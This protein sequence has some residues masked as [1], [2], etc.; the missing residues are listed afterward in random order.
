MNTKTILG[1]IFLSLAMT[2][3]GCYV[4]PETKSK[5][6]TINQVINN[7][8]KATPQALPSGFERREVA[9]ADGR[10]VSWILVTLKTD[11]WSWSLANDPSKPKTVSSWRE[12]L[13]ANLVINGSYFNQD[14]H[15]SGYYQEPNSSSS[16]PW[17]DL[18]AQKKPDSYSGLLKIRDG[19]LE[20]SHLTDKPQTKPAKNE[21]ALLTYP[22]LLANGQPLVKEDSKKY[23]RRTIL[24]QDAEGTTYL[25]I[26]ETGAL[27]LYEASRWLASQPEKFQIAINL[28]GGP[29][30]GLS[31]QTSGSSFEIPSAPIPNVITGI[32]TGQ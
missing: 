8:P 20:I 9:Y 16:K 25:V 1:I 3:S 7:Q 19:K 18:A 22:T 27:S 6:L 5:P 11:A 2:G 30:T 24:A 32:L 14:Y 28:D 31:Y 10:Q 17:P 21:Q 12:L 29:S 13:K 26:T 23:A 15:P 4:T